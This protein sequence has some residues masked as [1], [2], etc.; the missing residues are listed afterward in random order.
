ME[1]I[2]TNNRAE[3]KSFLRMLFLGIIIGVAAIMPGMSGGVLAISLGV[4]ATAI[5]AVTKLRTEFKKSFMYLLPLGLGASLGLL[6]FGFIMKPLL[7]S[8]ME[9][10]IWLFSGMILG[11]I[12][13]L[14]REA[15]EKGFR[16]MFFFPFLVALAMGI[17][18]S[19]A[20]SGSGEALGGSPVLYFLGGGILILGMII[21]GIS[22]SFIL[23]Q[24]GV[25]DD[26]IRAFTELDFAV[27]M[28]VAIGGAAFLLASLHLI[29]L[30][31]KKLHGYAYFASMGFLA[32]TLASV[33]PGIPGT[34]DVILFV[35]GGIGVYMF[36]RNGK[37]E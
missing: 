7:A 19:D 5:D 25:Y 28:W 22:S 6:L 20:V 29:N 4:Y 36:M 8:C 33:I 24:M 32:A 34:V 10:I 27:I 21:P 17:F 15:C 2:K 12:P 3:K 31:F 30:A 11:S 35:A 13:S 1:N 37:K 14:V 9:S 16:I 18:V 26:I 23:I